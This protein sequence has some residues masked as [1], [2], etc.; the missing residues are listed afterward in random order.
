MQFITLAEHPMRG[1]ADQTTQVRVSWRTDQT[2]REVV[3]RR[4]RDL[5]PQARI[6]VRRW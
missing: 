1:L 3:E 6:G 5:F 4:L 2:V